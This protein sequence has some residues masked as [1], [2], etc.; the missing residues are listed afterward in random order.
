MGF[1]RGLAAVRGCGFFGF[2]EDLSLHNQPW[3]ATTHGPERATSHT[4]CAAGSNPAATQH[5]R[6]KAAGTSIDFAP[7]LI[8]FAP[9]LVAKNV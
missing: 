7:D 2:A 4:R 3:L 8:A 9:L 6:G 5:G 1:T